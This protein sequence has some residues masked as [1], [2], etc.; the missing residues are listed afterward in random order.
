MTSLFGQVVGRSSRSINPLEFSDYVALLSSLGSTYPL[1]ALHQTLTGTRAEEI[2]GDFAGIAAGAHARSPVVF[3]AMM[4]R[5]LLFQE[6]RFQFRRLQ[7]GRPG[8]YFGTRDLLPLELPAPNVTTGDML[9][10]AIQ[11]VDL[12]GNWFGRAHEGGIRRMRPDWVSIVMGSRLRARNPAQAPDVEVLGYVFEP[13]GEEPEYFLVEE[14]AHWAPYPDPF[15]H[16]RGMSW[17]TPVLREVMADQAATD[18]KLKY[19]ENGATGNLVVTFD[20]AVGSETVRSWIDAMEKRI[21]GAANAYRCLHPTTEVALW[22]GA[23]CRAADVQVG[24]VVVSWADGKPVPGVVAAAEHQPP[25]PIVTVTTQRG[26]VIKTNDRHPFLTARG[27]VDAQDLR[28]GDLLTTG[29]GWGRPRLQDSLT[30]QD[31]WMVGLLVGDGCLVGSTA[32]VTMSDAGIIARMGSVATLVKRPVRERAPYDYRVLGVAELLRGLGLNGKRAYEK[33]VP[34]PVMTGGAEVVCAFLS[35]LIDADGHI[36]DPARRY[37]PDAGIT[38]TSRALLEDVQHLFASLGINASLS[39]PPSMRAGAPGGSSGATRRHDAHRLTV[40]GQAAR[41][42]AVLTLSHREKAR[43]LAVYAKRTSSQDRSRVDRVVSVVTSA[44]EMTIGIEVAG[45]HT[46]VT[47]GVVTHNTLYLGGGADA[48]VVGS[49]LRQI[50][51]KAT[52]SAGEN[53]ISIASG[54][55]PILIGI[56]A[57]LEAATYSNYSA[58]RRRFADGTMRPLWRNF[59]GSISRIVRV[60]RL[61]ELWIDD[62]DIPFLAEDM[63]DAAETQ[64]LNAQAIRQLIDGGFD[65]GSVV[66]AVTAGDLKRL[67]HTGMVSVQLQRPGSGGSAGDAPALPGR[68]QRSLRASYPRP[69]GEARLRTIAR[70]FADVEADVRRLLADAVRGR[71]EALLAQALEAV[72]GLRAERVADAVHEAYEA[73]Y[74]ATLSELEEKASTADDPV[75]PLADALEQKLN[76]GVAEASSRMPDAF[77][78][79]TAD[80]VDQRGDDAVTAFEDDAGRRWPL[81]AFAANRIHTLGRRATSRGVKDAAAGGDVQVS[82]HGTK[83]PVCKQLEGRAFPAVDAPEPPFHDGCQHTLVAVP[84]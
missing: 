65:P 6:A 14:V 23:R 7:N 43:R 53:R 4:V 52:Q 44:P 83:H 32:S 3:A 42:V 76:A 62:R 16:F 70:R 59:C 57:G 34:D 69:A 17:L 71:R 35:G 61:A 63:R 2:V 74:G 27:W 60:P 48:K 20:P 75:T 68:E 67:S 38:S 8:E 12:A 22:N 28:A 26:R 24:D 1:P 33:R 79:V 36:S 72:D 80:N 64:A 25:S 37:S 50:D 58:A 39:S 73:A 41:L 10:R 84:G 46:H 47:G 82:S 31:A 81:G 56:A 11:D 9:A 15:A 45:H 5:Q 51:F 54:V 21:G 19:F 13:P 66:D 30:P 18:H 55:P 77:R 49:D 29:L 40:S 78:G